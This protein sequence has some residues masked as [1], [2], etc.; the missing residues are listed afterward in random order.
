MST[1]IVWFRRDLRLTDQP[2]LSYAAQHHQHLIALYIHRDGED[3]PIGAASRWWLHHSLFALNESL[4]AKQS[5]LIIRQGQC[6][7]VLEKIIKES[8]AE[9]VF[10]NRLYEPHLIAR[11]SIIKET[12]IQKGLIV[13]SFNASL[14]NEPW[15]I[16]K[17]DGQPY[18]VFTAYMNACLKQSPFASK[19]L[20]AP[21]QLPSSPPIKSDSLKK[22]SLLPKIAWDKNF[23]A[24]WQP[25]ELGAHRTLN[26]FAKTRVSHYATARDFPATHGTSLLSPHLAFGEISAHTIHTTLSKNSSQNGNSSYLRQLYWRD[27]AN[28]LLFHFPDTKNQPLDKRFLHFAWRKNTKKEFNAWSKGQTGIPIVDAGM[29]ELWS[30]GWMHNRVRMITA[31]FLCKNLRISWQQGAQWFWDTLVDADLANNTMGWQWVAGCGAD[32]APYFR[33]FNPVLQSEKFD[34]GG[35]YLKKWVPEIA[36]LPNKYIHAPWQTPAEILNESGVVLGKTYPHP[37]VDLSQSRIDALAA[38]SHIKTYK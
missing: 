16:T 2:A 8:K 7:E 1:A 29:R 3:H 12:L 13:K 17:S 23:Y 14:L 38:F 37:I 4:I 35:D 24:C 18:Q 27:F 32:A 20:S 6:L 19:P 25:G 21:K 22:L 30:T 26:D 34:E 33:I 28:Y 31:S 15:A 10:W 5:R 9:A 11:D 36:G